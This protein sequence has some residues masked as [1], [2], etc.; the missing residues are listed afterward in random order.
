MVEAAAAGLSAALLAVW[1]PAREQ[2]RQ[3]REDVVVLAV[4][5]VAAGGRK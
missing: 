1:L 4:Q 2:L 5:L 3:E